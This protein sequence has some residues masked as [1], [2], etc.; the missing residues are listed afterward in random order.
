M[1]SAGVENDCGRTGGREH[2]VGDV[3]GERKRSR[4]FK[5]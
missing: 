3:A 1:I 5:G 2:A 4:A